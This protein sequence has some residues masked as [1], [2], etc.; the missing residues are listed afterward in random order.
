M[1]LPTYPFAKESHWIEIKNK[2]APGVHAL[3]DKKS[4]THSASV[5]SKQFTGNE[6]YLRDH[7]VHNEPVLPGT[8]CVEMSRVAASL[9]TQ[10]QR[11]NTIRNV[12]W[13]KPV[14]PHPQSRWLDGGEQPQGL[15]A[16]SSN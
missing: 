13:K 5:F 4:S 12:I 11:I 1:P 2:P 8:V 3:I 14:R 6:F 15:P 7:Q 16:I 10:N 9:G